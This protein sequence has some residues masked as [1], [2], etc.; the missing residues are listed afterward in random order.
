MLSGAQPQQ[1]QQGQ[2]QAAQ[3]Q[4]GAPLVPPSHATL[5]DVFH[6][7]SYVVSALKQ[8]LSKPDL[9]T[10]DILDTVGE[11]VADQVMSPFDAAKYLADMPTQADPLQLRQWV[12]QHYANSAKNL[13]TVAEMLHAHGAMTRRMA[14]QPPQMMP[15]DASPQMPPPDQSGG[16]LLSQTTQSVH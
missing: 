5:I 16:N 1:Q 7:G 9:K 6:R 10:K 4:P 14:Q 13:Q 2:P 8:L 11:I 15:P 3:G 12:G